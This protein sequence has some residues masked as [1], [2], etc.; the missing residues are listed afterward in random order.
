MPASRHVL[1]LLLPDVRAIPE[2]RVRRLPPQGAALLAAMCG[3]LGLTT[4]VVDL[5]RSAVAAPLDDPTGLL[6]DDGRL[7]A[8]AAQVS[9]PSAAALVAQVLARVGDLRADAVLLSLERHTQASLAALVG[10]ALKRH[11]GVPVA[12]GGASGGTL[13]RQLAAA[14]VVGIDVATAARTPAEVGAILGVLLGL[15]R[16]RREP[17]VE[18]LSSI[19]PPPSA[20]WPLPDFGVYDLAAYRQAL[21][22]D[23]PARGTL[24]LP[25]T[26]SFGC[27]FRCAFCQDAQPQAAQPAAKVVGDLAALGER[28][29][30]R[31]FLFLSCQ[32][33]RDGAALA[34]AVADAGLDVRWSDSWRVT[35]SPAGVFDTLARGGCVGLTFGVESASRR[36]LHRMRKGHRP[37]DAT[38]VVREAAATG[39]FTRVN[40]LPCFPGE[41]AA[42]LDETVAWVRANADAI[43]DLAP[44]S[45]YLDAESPIGR[46]PERFGLHLRGARELEGED[47][48]RKSARAVTY[49]EDGGLTWEE[50]QRTL[51]PAEEALRAAW[52]EGRGGRL[53]T[54]DLDAVTMLLLRRTH[55]TREGALAAALARRRATAA[56]V[57]PA[58]AGLDWTALRARVAALLPPELRETLGLERQADVLLVRFT[59]TGGG[60]HVLEARAAD[61][62][63]AWAYRE[64][65]GPGSAARYVG[66]YR[67][68]FQRLA[69]LEADLGAALQA[70]LA[71]APPPAPGEGAMATPHLL[72]ADLVAAA[73]APGPGGSPLPAV[74]ALLDRRAPPDVP[75][76]FFLSLENACDQ[77]CQFCGLDATRGVARPHAVRFP[78]GA[79]LLDT[80]AFAAFLAAL[81]SRPAP[82]ELC[83]TG[84]DWASHPRVDD[85]LTCLE[86]G[87][88]LPL[89]LYGPST[90]LADP[91]FGARVLA[92]PG[93]SGLRLTLHS[94]HPELHDAVSGTPGSGARVLRVLER[95]RERGL[96][97]RVNAVLT[98]RTVEGLDDLL[99][100][101]HGQEARLSL[102]AF[103]P[104]RGLV[105]FDG[106]SLLA[107]WSAT[108]Q[109]LERA[110]AGGVVA[111]DELIGLPTCAVPLAL[112]SRLSTSWNSPQGEGTRHVAVCQAC[113][114]R[115]S[116]LGVARL[117]AE[118][119]GDAGL[120]PEA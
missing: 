73:L 100:W 40:L 64:P 103:L 22:G 7:W 58:P 50:R 90:R 11:A 36:M 51:R 29:G 26:P 33:N 69:A 80:G 39:I 53:P 63:L 111:V 16:D 97:V 56:P 35:P 77:A 93:L 98:R 67:R 17:A 44:S 118:T 30:A 115:A 38:R 89:V 74:R 102:L 60:A 104:D 15:P 54:G 45:F 32:L 52:H 83:L 107:P 19:E 43:D 6:A 47:R 5:E 48:F 59:D 62:G 21:P 68:L 10:A 13:A 119:F 24:V 70:P 20:G 8:A 57:E 109:A 3:D 105:S 34:R 31:D 72:E 12:V 76:R 4:R 25:Y 113:R 116:C 1:I 117:Y 66:S 2:Q 71:A 75:A 55:A 49:D 101:A 61:G 85:L 106:P 81:A 112:R 94:P 95:A 27:A 82:T 86:Q 28:W 91:A 78:P 84:N 65:A 88:G 18:P 110:Q 37:E 114:R 120:S 9:D 14:G 23:D 42:E 46:A 96:A 108:R 99:A 92:L 79:D 87:P 41:T